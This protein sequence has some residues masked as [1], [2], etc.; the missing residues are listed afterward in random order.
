M[1]K[2]RF[3]QK[4]DFERL[5]VKR[6]A[7]Y[8]SIAKGDYIPPEEMTVKVLELIVPSL[9]DSIEEECWSVCM[10]DEQAQEMKKKVLQSVNWFLFR[11][12]T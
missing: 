3:K 1:K 7:L 6:K 12:N 5:E 9:A 11:Y 8:R 10:D 4:T 2:R